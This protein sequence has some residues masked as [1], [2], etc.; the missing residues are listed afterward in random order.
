MACCAFKAKQPGLYPKGRHASKHFHWR[1][2]PTHH[3]EGALGTLFVKAGQQGDSGKVQDANRA[4]VEATA[5]AQQTLAGQ[6][7]TDPAF[8]NALTQ[9]RGSG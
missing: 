2:A 3:A 5:I 1:A 6:W 4:A 9:A 7:W 8:Q